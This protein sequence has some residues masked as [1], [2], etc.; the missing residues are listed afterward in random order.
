MRFSE[1]N[2]PGYRISAYDAT[3]ITLGERHYAR[4][5]ALSPERLDPEWGP[6]HPEALSTE[7]IEALLA[8]SPEIIVLG[9]GQTQRFPPPEVQAPALQRGIGIEVMTTPAACRTYNI[10]AA[11]GRRVV[12]ALL[13][14]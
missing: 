1:D 2:S 14:D 3:S 13:I 12:A 8:D 6:E 5:L 4:S 7:H 9:T 10:L 11:E